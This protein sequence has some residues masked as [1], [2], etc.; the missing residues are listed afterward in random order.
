MKE[1][2]VLN[3]EEVAS[4]RQDSAFSGKITTHLNA[5]CLPTYAGGS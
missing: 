4:I 1:L 3:D 5:K 2:H